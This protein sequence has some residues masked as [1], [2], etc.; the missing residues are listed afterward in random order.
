MPLQFAQVYGAITASS[1]V[2]QHSKTRTRNRNMK[3]NDATLILGGALFGLI[4][5]VLAWGML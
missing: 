4:F 1:C 2:N 5:A 3:S